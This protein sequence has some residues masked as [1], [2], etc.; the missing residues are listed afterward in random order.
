[1]V[2]YEC[3][4]VER[5]VVGRFIGNAVIPSLGRCRGARERSLSASS[6]HMA[7]DGNLEIGIQQCSY[8][9][10]IWAS[11]KFVSYFHTII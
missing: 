3:F 1:M 2:G 8:F 7:E 6:D 11:L 4:V 10:T 5:V 9:A